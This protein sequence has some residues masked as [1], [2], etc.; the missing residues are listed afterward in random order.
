MRNIFISYRRADAEHESDLIYQT[1]AAQFGVQRVFRDTYSIPFGSDFEA[2]IQDVLGQCNV[3][4]VVIGPN[5]L[6]CTD[7]AGQRRL[8]HADDLVR[9]EVEAG[10]RRGI[11]VYAIL[12]NGAQMPRPETLPDSL[13]PLTK[14]NAVP[15]ENAPQHDSRFARLMTELA[16][17]LSTREQAPGWERVLPAHM[18]KLG[19]VYQVTDSSGPGAIVPPSVQ[20]ASHALVAEVHQGTSWTAKHPSLPSFWIAAYPVT[21]A[22]YACFVR[23]QL[24][25]APSG[26][27]INWESQLSHLD[28]PVV[29]VSWEDAVAYTNWLARITG[30]RWR[31]PTADEWEKAASW[32]PLT[33]QI[34]AYP[35]GDQFDRSRCNTTESRYRGTTPIGKF[36]RGMTSC[37]AHD[38]AGN[39]W[40][41][42]SSPFQDKADLRRVR[43]GG[44][45]RDTGNAAHCTHRVGDDPTFHDGHIGFRIACGL[46]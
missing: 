4:L 6:E 3:L 32:D 12:V 14:A 7:P 35:W 43:R 5:W 22:E 15:L 18:D 25:P 39:V 2:Q 26:H 31:L 19:F 29:H 10:L 24:H 44:S 1:L 36:L 17:M 20:V 37:G 46:G 41:W 30:A 8:D 9:S 42:T 23:T 38:M 27:D 28:H 40:E 11:T 16:P 34:H 13:R 45:W 21:V 33:G